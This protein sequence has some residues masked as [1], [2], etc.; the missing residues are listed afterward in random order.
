MR[1]IVL[2]AAAAIALAFSCA[3]AYAFGGSNLA[4]GASPYAILE[5][6]TVLP[7]IGEGRAVY[8][9]GDAGAQPSHATHKR[10]NH[11]LRSR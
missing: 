2:F 9:S 3:G 5:Q 7:A 8:S 4:P 11:D 6:Q 10:R 1:N